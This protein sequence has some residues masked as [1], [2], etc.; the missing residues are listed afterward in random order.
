[1]VLTDTLAARLLRRLGIMQVVVIVDTKLHAF[2]EVCTCSA[3]NH[4]ELSPGRSASIPQAG[5]TPRLCS[6]GQ[7]LPS[8]RSVSGC[9]RGSGP[10][11]I[12]AHAQPYLCT[13]GST[14]QPQDWNKQQR[15]AHFSRQPIEQ[16][17]VI[18]HMWHA[19]SGRPSASTFFSHPRRAQSPGS[20]TLDETCSSICHAPCV[21]IEFCGDDP[22]PLATK[23]A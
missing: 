17:L 9:L 4:L 13:L 8:S 18:L 14:S 20:S 12:C 2:A 3:S 11:R 23:S 7:I 19:C 21:H 22:M 6:R 16:Y 15:L 10:T 1:M 5:E